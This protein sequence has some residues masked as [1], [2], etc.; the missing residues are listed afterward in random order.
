[1]KEWYEGNFDWKNP[2]NQYEQTLME[3]RRP[4]SRSRP[5]QDQSH[6]Q[7]QDHVQNHAQDPEDVVHQFQEEDHTQDHVQDHDPEDIYTQ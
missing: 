1:M 6:V 2:R 7:D 3:I 5:D 4:R